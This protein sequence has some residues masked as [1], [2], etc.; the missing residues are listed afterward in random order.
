MAAK[1]ADGY[2][3]EVV[4]QNAGH[5]WGYMAADG[6]AVILSEEAA[7]EGVVVPEP[8]VKPISDEA[9][10]VAMLGLLGMLGGV[11]AFLF[12][13]AMSAV[14]F[15]AAPVVKQTHTLAFLALAFAALWGMLRL[16]RIY[17]RPGHPQYLLARVVIKTIAWLLVIF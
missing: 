10:V 1:R 17:N 4:H 7:P 9:K 5:L 16:T 8:P 2:F 11:A 12:V 13:A 15:L 6:F 14:Q 3:A